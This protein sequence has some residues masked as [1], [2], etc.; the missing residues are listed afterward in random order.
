[1]FSPSFQSKTELDVGLWKKQ[2]SRIQYMSEKLPK[3]ESH[4][5]RDA[6]NEQDQKEQ[7]FSGSSVMVVSWETS[8]PI[9]HKEMQ[10]EPSI[11]YI[12]I[13]RSKESQEMPLSLMV[14]VGV[15]T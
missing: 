13:Q 11:T 7:H 6:P 9:V 15:T 3:K 5:G 10:L 12:A 2:V 8:E 14:L 4:F 1:M